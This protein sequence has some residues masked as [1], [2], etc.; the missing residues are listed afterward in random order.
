M[1]STITVQRDS[2][3]KV[4]AILA[5]YNINYTEQP[6]L[7]ESIF[8]MDIDEDT[9]DRLSGAFTRENLKDGAI[10]FLCGSVKVAKSIIG[11]AVVD[12]GVPVAKTVAAG[13]IAGAGIAVRAGVEGTCGILNATVS[14]VKDTKNKLSTSNEYITAKNNLGGLFKSAKNLFGFSTGGIKLEK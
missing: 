6:G 1:R 12:I 3:E 7:K 5:Q 11:T 2:V 8:V 13:A 9:Y 4:K 14:E 10:K